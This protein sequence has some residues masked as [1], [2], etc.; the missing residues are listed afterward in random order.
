MAMTVTRV[1]TGTFVVNQSS[2]NNSSQ[3]MA[4]KV[5]GCRF[6]ASRIDIV[7]TTTAWSPIV[8]IVDIGSLDEDRVVHVSYGLIRHMLIQ[9]DKIA[10]DR[11]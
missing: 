7:D 4:R 9:I 8:C 1:S 5:T 11:S 6:I 2:A 10:V 3:R